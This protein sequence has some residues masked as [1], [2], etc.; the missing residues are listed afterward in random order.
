MMEAAKVALLQPEE[1]S[2]P[3]ITTMGEYTIC[4]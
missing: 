2:A 3:K 1:G 4:T